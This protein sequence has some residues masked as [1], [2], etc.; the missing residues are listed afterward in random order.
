MSLV[1][2]IRGHS[3]KVNV[4]RWSMFMPPKI[5][6]PEVHV[7]YLLVIQFFWRCVRAP[8]RWQ[9]TFK[10]TADIRTCLAYQIPADLYEISWI[11][12]LPYTDQKLQKCLR[13]KFVVRQTDR[14][15]RRTSIPRT[16]P[17][18]HTHKHSITPFGAIAWQ[19]SASIVRQKLV[20]R[21]CSFYTPM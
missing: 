7:Y 17:P 8:I 21:K 5:A 12:T 1:V 11:W 9:W 6:W 13:D 14:Q 4:T 20:N 10:C 16:I 15:K 18:T 2:V 3:V 19:K